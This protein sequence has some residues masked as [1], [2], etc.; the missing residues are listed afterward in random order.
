MKLTKL[1]AGIL[2]T[3]TLVTGA[4]ALDLNGAMNALTD[5]KASGLVGEQPNG[6]LGVVKNS[7]DAQ[8]ITKLINDARKAEYQ[9]V[10][11]DNGISLGDVE[12]MAGQKAIDKTPKGQYIQA[13][14]QWK[15]K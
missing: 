2:L 13:N 7:G 1:F 15:A 9:K 4:W 5:A 11:K 3:S 8:Q 14:G 10:A 6:Y 12:S